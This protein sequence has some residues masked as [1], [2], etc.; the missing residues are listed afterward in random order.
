[1]KKK[2]I[3]GFNPLLI[4]AVWLSVLVSPVKA[5]QPDYT[6]YQTDA[7]I[8]FSQ[9]IDNDIEL[10]GP[11]AS[12]SV[13]F[14]PPANWSLTSGGRV[15]LLMTLAYNSALQNLPNVSGFSAGKLLV[16]LNDIL[17]GV[18]VFSQPGAVSQQ[19]TIPIEALRTNREDGLFELRFTMDSGWSCDVNDTVFLAIHTRSSLTLSYEN[20]V[21]KLDL[22]KFPSPMYQ[23]N[24]LFPSSAIVV[25]PDHP[26][27]AELRSA[28]TVAAGFGNVTSGG[29]GLTLMTINQLSSDQIAGNHLILVGKPSSVSL[30][31]QLELPVP[32]RDGKFENLS[33][34]SDDGIVVLVNS[35]WNNE[36]VVLLVSGNTDLG[37]LKAAQSVSTGTLMPNAAPNFAIIEQVQSLPVPLISS[38]DMTLFELGYDDEELDEIG[39]NYSDFTFYIPPGQTVAEDAYFDLHFGHSALLEFERSGIVARL[40]GTPIG[41]IALTEGSAQIAKN[42]ARLEIPSS[43]VLT[44]ENV[45][46][47]RFNL[48]PFDRC[49]PPNAS[50]VYAN[51]WADSLFHLPLT[52]AVINPM[53][54]Y[55]LSAYPIP[56]VNTTSLETTA[57]VLP[58]DDLE[59]WRAAFDIAGYLGNRA[60]GSV[61][62]ISSYYDDEVPDES[63]E[64]SNFFIIGLPS[65]LQII[66]EINE[67]LPAPFVENSDIA[68]EPRMEVNY[69]LSPQS[70]VGYIEM[71]LSPWNN[72]NVI[73]LAVGNTPQSVSWA[74]SYLIEPRSYELQGNFAIVNEQKVYPV[75]TRLTTITPEMIAA[76]ETPVVEVIPS[77]RDP[78][79]FAQYQPYWIMPTFFAAVSVILITLIVVAY[80][81]WSL[82]RSKDKRPKPQQ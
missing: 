43:L 78:D 82:T 20:I 70:A 55:T 26:S 62:L 81:G 18:V 17:I 80:R 6:V 72:D 69:R 1:M 61:I 47:V 24:S 7:S 16:E 32:L 46:E 34:E 25:I 66:K 63:R 23:R 37:I 48:I 51:I 52:H 38:T 33:G 59:S 45:L 49:S 50:A 21:P 31:S 40:N 53:S 74:A 29:L 58:R 9:L 67:F 73:L 4:C 41:S 10:V 57:F 76:Q 2:L 30:F 8:S 65:K 79:E 39:V 56:F 75:D 12:D 11:Y 64:N 13:F 60:G 42:Q 77:Q 68:I 19:F 28:L 3:H 71:L 35:P 14:T 22:V 27:S 54:N 5:Y 36:K 15:D 44:G